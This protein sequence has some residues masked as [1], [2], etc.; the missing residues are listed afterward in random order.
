MNA[1]I[2]LFVYNRPTHT[3]STVTALQKNSRA[4]NSD[5]Y[6]FSDA[7]KSSADEHCVNS[8]R[9]YISNISGFRNVSIY[10]QSENQG[11]SQSIIHGINDILG[12]RDKIIVMEDDIVT[13][14]YF[15]DYMNDALE[16]YQNHTKVISISGYT[17]PVKRSLPETFFLRGADCWGW[18]TWKR[19]WELF[20]PDS[21]F[22]LKEIDQHNLG[23]HFDFDG[24]YNFRRML[25]MH[26]NGL[27][28]SWAIRWYASAFLKNK[29]TLYPGQSLVHNIGNDGEGTHSH[30]SSVYAQRVCPDRV[31]VNHIPVKENNQ[32]REMYVDYL[33]SIRPHPIL[34]FIKTITCKFREIIREI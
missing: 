28:D 14:P 23:F 22:L 26:T 15:L 30:K 21:H 29:L 12:Y 1:P 27:N 34:R 20:N 10:L 9:E 25:Q 8:V 5:L 32:V 33:R 18:A 13:S 17:Y 4:R 2:A 31:W 16:Y 3:K 11:L 7:A 24:T 19:G 6:V